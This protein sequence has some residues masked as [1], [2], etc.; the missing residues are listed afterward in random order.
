MHK[1]TRLR[2]FAAALSSLALISACGGGGSSSP[3][4][5]PPSPPPS[6]PAPPPVNTA[7]T[8]STQS[9][10]TS[11]EVNASAQL[12]A[13]DAENH[14]LTFAIAT[15][16]QHG[17]ATLTAAGALSYAPASNYFGSDSLTVT[18][19]DSVGAQ[20]TGTVNLTVNNIN[21][22]P[23]VQDDD[24]RV[25]VPP[26]QPI[27]LGALANDQDDDG[28]ALVPDIVAQP[29]HGGTIAVD[30]TTRIITFLPTNVYVGPISFSY[31]VNDGTVDSEVAT[32]RAVIG[33]FD[34]VVFLSDYTTPGVAEVHLYD[35]FEVRVLSDPQPPG[36]VVTSYSFS[37]DL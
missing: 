21:D 14:A 6:A 26:G 37:D 11:E 1:Q 9:L 28:D 32:V 7:P 15:Q 2:A 22:A 24:L 29:A 4:P 18:V 16:P 17:T 10:S 20:T 13:T 25:S 19:T 12:T 34:D 5:A 3:S 33:D 8:F 35:G 27:V 30:A 23:V 36:T 31:R